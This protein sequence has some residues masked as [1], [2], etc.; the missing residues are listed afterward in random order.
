MLLYML[1]MIKFRSLDKLNLHLQKPCEHQT[2]QGGDFLNLKVT[3]PFDHVNNVL[4]PE[5]LKKDRISWRLNLAGSWLEGGGSESKSR[6][7]LLSVRITFMRKWSETHNNNSWLFF[8]KPPKFSKN[9]NG[10]ND[11][12]DLFY[13]IT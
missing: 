2:K 9:A 3:W 11:W 13:S 7:L 5:N 12:L 6:H 4:S 1:Y 10:G 8:N